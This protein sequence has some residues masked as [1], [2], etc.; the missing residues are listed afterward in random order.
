MKKIGLVISLVVAVGLVCS[1]MATPASAF[2]FGGG[3][4]CGD[5]GGLFKSGGLFG[6]G[7]FGGF[8]GGAKAGYGYGSGYGMPYYGSYGCCPTYKCKV[9]KKKAKGAAKPAPAK[10]A[11]TK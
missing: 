1:T 2:L 11:K 4:G 8:L 6:G 3:G 10:K 7:A 9:S 5:S